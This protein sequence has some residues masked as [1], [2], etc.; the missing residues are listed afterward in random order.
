M[1]PELELVC[2]GAE[3][4]TGRT[5]NRHVQ[6][7]GEKVLDLG[8]RLV[9]ETTVSDDL[10][11][12]AS[13][14]G[15]ALS[16]V[17]VVL[18][19]GGLGPTSDDVTREAIA[20]LLDRRV[21]LDMGSLEGLKAKYK[22]MNRELTPVSERQ[23]N[24]VEGAVVLPNAM[25]MAPGQRL[26]LGSKTLFI[27]PGPPR[28]FMAVLGDH[29]LPWLKNAFPAREPIHQRILM[30]CGVGESDVATRLES[31]G[32]PPV[33][34]ELAYCAG[35]GRTEV[36][37]TGPASRLADIESA[38]IRVHEIMGHHVYSDD[39]SSMEDVVARLLSERKLTVATAESCTGGG[40]GQRLTSLAGSSSY[41]QGGIIAYSNAV[42]IAHLGV[43][44]D[45]LEAHGAVSEETAL[46]MARGVRERFQ[47]DYGVSLTGIA[48]PG[49]G[50]EEKPV[51]LVF[52]GV[53]DAKGT[54]AEK[55]RFP[56][57][58][59]WVRECAGFL[60]LDLLRRRVLGK[61]EN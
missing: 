16:R 54:V 44:V 24:V 57:D 61:L 60:A 29:V 35:G 8:L 34:I 23:I 33:G 45:V 59:N 17:D 2:T 6:V 28:E 55:R 32:L 18:V 11:A 52:M 49:G 5:L 51:G 40:V 41:Y 38:A 31:S 58:R 50:T 56:G 37:L 26:D 13:A 9:R 20:G 3:L 1:K 42:K 19:T 47:T 48:G 39:R 7:L 36:R 12:I 43:P 4:L 10:A 27:L 53:A 15:L 14:T 46:A 25:G 30:I 22:R 21:V